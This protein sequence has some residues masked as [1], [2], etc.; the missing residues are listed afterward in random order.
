MVEKN[1]M[2]VS[3]KIQQSQ[4]PSP[5]AQNNWLELEMTSDR[6]PEHRSSWS[7]QVRW[8]DPDHNL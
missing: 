8:T 4:V 2:R 1:T 7:V 5:S 3:V 6:H